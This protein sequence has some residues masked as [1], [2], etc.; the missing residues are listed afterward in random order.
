[1]KIYDISGKLLNLLHN[2]LQKCYQQVVLN[3]QN[4]LW[5]DMKSGIPKGLAPAPLLFLIN[6]NDLPDNLSSVKLS[7]L[8]IHAFFSAMMLTLPQVTI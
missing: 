8:T 4:S 5:H 2:Y 1:M 7:L 3:G 6:I